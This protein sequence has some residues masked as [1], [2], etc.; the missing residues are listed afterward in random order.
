VWTIRNYSGN[1]KIMPGKVSEMFFVGAE[2]RLCIVVKG[3]S[4]GYWG[5]TIFGSES[6][7]LEAMRRENMA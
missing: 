3:V 4:R 5:K 7:A 6:E 1:K 2:M